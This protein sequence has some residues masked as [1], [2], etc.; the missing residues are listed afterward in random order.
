MGASLY[1]F[2]WL[3]DTH[4]EMDRWGAGEPA[5]TIAHIN[6]MCPEFVIVSGD[7]VND[8]TDVANFTLYKNTI[9]DALD[10]PVYNIP[11][12]PF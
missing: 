7:L 4:I 2:V 6:A 10:C 12:V 11:E 5:A 8:S 3:T 1:R 9:V